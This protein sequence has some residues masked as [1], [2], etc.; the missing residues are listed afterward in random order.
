M[1][2]TR[3]GTTREL[4]R[5]TIM[6]LVICTV[7]SSHL[8]AQT[9]AKPIQRGTLL[10]TKTP[11]QQ[12]VPPRTNV[13]T[14]PTPQQEQAEEEIVVEIAE[15][16]VITKAIMG[17]KFKRTHE[18]IFQAKQDLELDPLQALPPMPE[19]EDGQIGHSKERVM[20]IAEQYGRIIHAS[21]WDLL[22]NLLAES[23]VGAESRQIRNI[24]LK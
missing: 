9:K 12:T 13:P 18:T 4:L 2:A 19:S 22:A 20:A 1:N 23:D 15:P 10:P 7:S 5:C 8:V 16:G 11:Q 6:F 3:N 14:Q 24:L 21:R 17:Q